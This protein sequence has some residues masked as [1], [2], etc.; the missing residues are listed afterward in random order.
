LVCGSK[1]VG[2]EKMPLRIRD[3]FEKEIARR[4]RVIT[5]KK[6]LRLKAAAH[7][8]VQGLGL[9]IFRKCPTIIGNITI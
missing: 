2:V 1:G 6:I 8:V 9:T 5:G 4:T 3:R 7:R